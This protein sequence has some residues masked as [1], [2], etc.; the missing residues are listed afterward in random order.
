[1]VSYNAT[2]FYDRDR[3]LQGVFAAARDVTERKRLDQALKEQNVEW[4]RARS[5]GGKG[6]PREIGF[7]FQ[8]EPRASLAAQRHS[9]V[10]SA[11]EFR[12]AAADASQTA[13]IDQILHAGWYL[14]ELINEILDLAQIESGKLA[15]SLGTT[16]L[17]EVIS[18]ARP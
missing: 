13:S 12:L 8:H 15:L 17:G 16:S 1:M 14:L 6:Q 11:H 4:K 7:P 3:K 2:T 10:R 18:N 5:R 9:R